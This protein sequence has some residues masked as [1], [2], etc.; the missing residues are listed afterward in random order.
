MTFIDA[1]GVLADSAELLSDDR[2]AHEAKAIVQNIVAA[3]DAL[4]PDWAQ[5]PEWAN[6]YVAQ[7]VIAWWCQGEPKVDEAKWQ[8]AETLN[9]RFCIAGSVEISLGIDWR[10]C[11]WQRHVQP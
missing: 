7:G 1:A 9:D 6:W 2:M 10:L 3:Y 4:E 8:L 5:A 11:I